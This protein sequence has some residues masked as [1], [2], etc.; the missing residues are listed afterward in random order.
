MYR[1]IYATACLSACV[2]AYSVTLTMCLSAHLLSV[3]LS[4]CLNC[5][6]KCLHF[7]LSEW[8][9][10]FLLQSEM[11]LYVI[12]F[13]EKN[14]TRRISS[15]LH[16]IEFYVILTRIVL[17]MY[18]L[19]S[20]MKSIKLLLSIQSISAVLKLTKTGDVLNQCNIWLPII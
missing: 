10:H 20:R 7:L 18:D 11:C 3:K 13:H 14:F 2:W 4:N 9:S 1:F 6:Q 5:L 19:H 17:I 16:A 8:S 12:Q 15:L